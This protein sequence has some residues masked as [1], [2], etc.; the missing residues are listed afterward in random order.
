M[1]IQLQK[2]PESQSSG[3]FTRVFVQ[4]SVKRVIR[5]LYQDSK[6]CTIALGHWVP[7]SGIGRWALDRH[8]S[9]CGFA[10]LSGPGQAPDRTEGNSSFA[11]THPARFSYCL[12]RK[13][14]SLGRSQRT[15][16][17]S[18][19]AHGLKVLADLFAV[20]GHVL[21]KWLFFRF[22]YGVRQDFGPNNDANGRTALAR[23]LRHIMAFSHH[24]DPP[25]AESYSLVQ[26]PA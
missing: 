5:P 17:F 14:D 22:A 9:G 15:Y 24:H 10:T 26:S 7:L 3:Y 1:L 20:R 6:H 13:R 11:L 12:H 16:V 19:M 23:D 4:Q 18:V 25:Q 2:G 21:K 8:S